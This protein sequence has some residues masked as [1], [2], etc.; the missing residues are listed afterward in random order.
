M[1]LAE[2][3]ITADGRLLVRANTAIDFDILMRM[4]QL[5]AIRKIAARVKVL[6]S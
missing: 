3:L 2:P 6:R 5:L 1:R 4:L